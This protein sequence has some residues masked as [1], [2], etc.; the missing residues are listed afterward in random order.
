MLSIR[1]ITV[2]VAGRILLEDA[3]ASIPHGH[4]VGLI[5]RNGTGK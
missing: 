5:G 4:H 1:N 2:R 3:T